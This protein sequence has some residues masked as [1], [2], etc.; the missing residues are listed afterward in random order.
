MLI[1]MHLLHTKD[2]DPEIVTHYYKILLKNGFA[3]KARDILEK[4]LIDNP[5]NTELLKLMDDSTDEAAQL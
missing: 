3:N 2:Q 1:S 5:K 4:S